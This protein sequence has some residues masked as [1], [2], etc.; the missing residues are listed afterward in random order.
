M[1]ILLEICP[2]MIYNKYIIFQ[3]GESMAKK[4]KINFKRLFLCIVCVYA[5][6]RL[7]CGFGDIFTLKEQKAQLD[8]KMEEALKQQEILESQV[9]KM[10][11]PEEME[12]LAREQLGYVLPG[13]VSLE[14]IE[15]NNSNN[16]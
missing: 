6:V 1:I 4:S 13:E 7:I 8:A 10:S 3:R 12:R 9:D 2:W 5:A 16:E 15:D 11:T 14:K